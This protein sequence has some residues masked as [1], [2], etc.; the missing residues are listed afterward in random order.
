[1]TPARY[2]WED[3]PPGWNYES[4]SRTLSAE[5]IT[6]Y[7]REYDPQ[8][9]HTDAQAAKASPFGGLIASGWQT[10]SVAMRLMCDGYLL[11]T[12]CIGSPGL[13]ELR[14]LKP[15]R[16]GDALRLRSTVLE[17]MASQKDPARGT[18]RFRWDVLNQKD[19]VVC[20]MAGRQH[21]RRRTPAR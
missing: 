19:E 18:V 8:I 12:S 21:F 15:V 1:M 6:A 17:Q 2:Y 3:F 5:E 9:Y 11:E 14:W 4:P 7:G 10:C 20:T 16:P 13:E